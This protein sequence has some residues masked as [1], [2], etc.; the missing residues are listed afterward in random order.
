MTI[1]TTFL[2]YEMKADGFDALIKSKIMTLTA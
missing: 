1:Y 2:E